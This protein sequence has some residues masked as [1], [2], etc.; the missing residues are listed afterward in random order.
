MPKTKK[1]LHCVGQSTCVGV[2]Q[3]A[4]KSVLFCL[5]KKDVLIKSDHINS[6]NNTGHGELMFDQ[7]HY[8]VLYLQ[9]I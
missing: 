1:C 5:H 4:A 6:V 8:S 3:L 2:G 9:S 7:L